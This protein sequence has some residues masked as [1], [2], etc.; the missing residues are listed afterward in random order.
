MCGAAVTTKHHRHTQAYKTKTPV[1]PFHR[2]ARVIYEQVEVNA[3]KGD[4]ARRAMVHE[5]PS[6]RFPAKRRSRACNAECVCG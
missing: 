6:L 2:G 4:M 1:Q 3:I 5:I